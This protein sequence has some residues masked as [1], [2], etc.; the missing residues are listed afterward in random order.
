MPNSSE[1]IR[2]V[3]ANATRT[4]QVTPAP[5]SRIHAE[6]YRQEFGASSF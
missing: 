1:D 2:R 6:I 4:P 3:S 5:V